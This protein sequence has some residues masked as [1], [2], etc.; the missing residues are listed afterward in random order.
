MR[1]VIIGLA[2]LFAIPVL[3]MALRGNDHAGTAQAADAE[4]AADQAGDSLGTE[5]QPAQD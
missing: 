3:G 5:A 1:S 2:L 4:H